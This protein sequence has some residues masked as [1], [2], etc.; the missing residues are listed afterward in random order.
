MV[1]DDDV[2]ELVDG[3]GYAKWV[4]EAVFGAGEDSEWE[5]EELE[6]VVRWRWRAVFVHVGFSGSVIKSLKGML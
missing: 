4:G 6:V 2:L 1:E 5:V 3:P